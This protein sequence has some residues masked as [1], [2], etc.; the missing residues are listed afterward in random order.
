MFQLS[1]NFTFRIARIHGHHI[2]NQRPGNYLFSEKRGQRFDTVGTGYI[3][4]VRGPYHEGDESYSKHRQVCRV[5]RVLQ[6]G[7]TQVW[8]VVVSTA[9]HVLFDQNEATSSELVLFDHYDDGSGSVILHGGLFVWGKT[10]QDDSLH[11]FFTHDEKLADR[12]SQVLAIDKE[13][14]GQISERQISKKSGVVRAVIKLWL[15]LWSVFS[16]INEMDA[17]AIL[18]FLHNRLPVPLQLVYKIL[19]SQRLKADSSRPLMLL[20]HPHGRKLYISLGKYIQRSTLACHSWCVYDAKSCCGSS[21]GFI[22]SLD[23]LFNYVPYAGR[24]FHSNTHSGV[25]RDSD[26]ISHRNLSNVSS[27]NSVG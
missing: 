10:V 3:V 15:R 22:L 20:S 17:G 23:P 4:D 13:I 1:K 19:I 21:G 25:T 9:R 6:S 24:F 12:L 2:S 8:G 18:V 5:C 11:M 14:R 16:N 7:N 27:L 26:G